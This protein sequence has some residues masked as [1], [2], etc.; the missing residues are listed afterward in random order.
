[1]RIGEVHACILFNC[2]CRA[3]N[4]D[5]NAL[6]GTVLHRNSA[7]A[8]GHGGGQVLIFQNLHGSLITCAS[9]ASWKE[10]YRLPFTSATAADSFVT[11]NALNPWGFVKVAI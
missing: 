7:A 4:R 11:V 3:V 2:L 5:G 10:V 1:M 9:T 6:A 8:A